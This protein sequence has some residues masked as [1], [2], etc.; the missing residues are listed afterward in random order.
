MQAMRLIVET[1]EHGQILNLPRLS[2][3]VRLEAIFLELEESGAGG[4]YDPLS[5]IPDRGRRT[6]EVGAP[7]TDWEPPSPCRLGEFQAPVD[8]WRILANEPGRPR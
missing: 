5:A 2:P 8:D 1:D 3:R 4:R 7:P 6:G